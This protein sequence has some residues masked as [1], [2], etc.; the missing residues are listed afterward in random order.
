MIYQQLPTNICLGVTEKTMFNTLLDLTVL[1]FWEPNTLPASKS[2]LLGHGCTRP[3][4]A[5]LRASQT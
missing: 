3:G 2:R 5:R 4:K 1:R